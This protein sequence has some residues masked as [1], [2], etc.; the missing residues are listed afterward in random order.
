MG[1]M[2]EGLALELEQAKAENVTLKAK[3]KELEADNNPE[4]N[5]GR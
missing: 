3:I 5:D 2:I 4:Q 1:G